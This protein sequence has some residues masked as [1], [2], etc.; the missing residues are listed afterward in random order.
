[1]IAACKCGLSALLLHFSASLQ[2]V[3]LPR[4]VMSQNVPL[5]L[6]IQHSNVVL[7]EI[8]DAYPVT[9]RVRYF[10]FCG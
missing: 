4:L 1:M 8:D 10:R 5:R 2:T 9:G 6:L 7:S 3:R